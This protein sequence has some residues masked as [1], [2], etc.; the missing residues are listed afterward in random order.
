MSEAAL[1]A[2]PGWRDVLRALSRPKVA[3]MLMLGFSAGIPFML[4]GNTLGFWLRE[5]GIELSTIGFLSRSA[6]RIQ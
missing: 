1:K 4:V 5:G 3:V 6:S 2:K